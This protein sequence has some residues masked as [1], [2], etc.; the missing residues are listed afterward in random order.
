MPRFT[1]NVMLLD[2]NRSEKIAVPADSHVVADGRITFYT[3]IEVDSS[4]MGQN[5][6][7][8]F[9]LPVHWWRELTG[10]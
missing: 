4:L 1:Y 10:E 6:V 7:A 2:G 9:T 3:D 8:G 5:E